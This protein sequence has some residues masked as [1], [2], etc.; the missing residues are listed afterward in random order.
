VLK[1]QYT[2]SDHVLRHCVGID[3]STLF[4]ARTGVRGANDLVWVGRAANYAA[5]LSAISVGYPT[6]IS[7]SIYESL[8]KTLKW[9]RMAEICGHHS[10]NSTFRG[11]GSTVPP[12][13]GSIKTIGS[14]VECENQVLHNDIALTGSAMGLHFSRARARGTHCCVHATHS[15]HRGDRSAEREARGGRRPRRSDPHRMHDIRP[16]PIKRLHLGREGR[17]GRLGHGRTMAHVRVSLVPGGNVG[18]VRDPE[19]V[20]CGG[21]EVALHKVRR[22]AYIAVTHGGERLPPTTHALEVSA[23]YGSAGTS[24]AAIPAVRSQANE[25]QAAVAAKVASVATH[26]RP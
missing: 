12:S 3:A 7:A 6:V 4:V 16:P 23:R 18:N 13:C 14:W 9:H 15:D 20:R 11:L 17:L 19:L 22:R 1:L 26:R 10:M 2:A 8:H 25:R 24:P 21:G 5:K